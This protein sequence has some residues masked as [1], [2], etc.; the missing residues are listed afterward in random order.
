MIYILFREPS[1]NNFA[2]NVSFDASPFFDDFF[3]LA[4]I[5]TFDVNRK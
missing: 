4:G 1:L 5:S 2:S 3:H